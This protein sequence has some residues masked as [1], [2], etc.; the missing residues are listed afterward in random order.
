[1]KNSHP[2]NRSTSIDAVWTTPDETVETI[3]EQLR[4]LG[5]HRQ[6]NAPIL[7]RLSDGRIAPT[8]A[9]MLRKLAQE[10][11]A[12]ILKSRLAELIDALCPQPWA[13]ESQ[14]PDYREASAAAN[15]R[16]LPVI[17]TEGGRPA[18]L[19]L[20]PS[21]RVLQVAVDREAFDL[22]DEPC[23]P[24]ALA[25]TQFVTATLNT[26]VAKVAL[27]LKT[28][29]EPE[30]AYVVVEMDDGSF[31]VMTARD[32]NVDVKKAGADVWNL[33]LRLFTSRLRPAEVRECET[34]GQKQAQALA[35]KKKFLVLTA[36]GKPVGLVLSQD[37]PRSGEFE[38]EGPGYDLFGAPQSFLQSFQAE[39][40][41]KKA[42]RYVNLWFEDRRQRPINRTQALIIGDTYYLAMNV[43]QLQSDLSIINWE[44]KEP[45]GPQ[46]IV[47]P[48]EKEAHLYVSISSQDFAIPEPTRQLRLPKE[49]ST[50][51]IHIQLEPLHRSHG[52]DLA[53]LDVYLYYRTYLV[54]TFRVEVQVVA[55]NEAA[56]SARPQSAELTHARTTDFPQ[57]EKLPP[58]EMSLTITRNGADRY[59]FTFLIDPDLMDHASADKAIEL[60]CSVH[61]TRDDLTHLITKARRQLYN[62]AQI[63]DL[64]QVRDE[65][66][67]QR[68]T[69]ALARVGRQL[70]LKLFESSSARALRDW[71]EASLPEGST[72]Q[73]VDLAGDFVF[74]WSLVYTDQPW[75][76]D[77]PIDVAK[78]WGWRYKLV[79]LTSSLLDNYRQ[80]EPVISTDEPLRISIGLHERLIGADK[81]KAFFADLAS[82]TGH[83][84]MPEILTNRRV[85]SHALTDA[86][87]D[88][89]Y[90]FCHG[91]T[92]RIA[93]D[94]QLD[95]DLVAHFARTATENLASR[96]Q[97]IRDHLDDL[98]DVSDSWIRLT[99]GRLPLAM[100]KETV[101]DS[102]SRHPVVFLNMCE[103][104]QVL[105][106]LSDGFVPFFIQRGAR[107][108]IGTEC[109]MN[110]L[111][112]D[113]FAR[114]FLT[115]FFQ[116]EA[117]GDILLALR[118]HYL[119]QGNPLA[120]AY[121]LYCD[122]DL[123]LKEPVL[124]L[125]HSNPDT[126]EESLRTAVEMLWE[127]DLE[128]LMLTLAARIQV[129]EQGTTPEELQKWNPPE[130]TFHREA[131]ASPEAIAKMKAFAQKW[132]DNLEPKLYDLICNRDNEQ[133][134]Q[135]MN[136]L[137][138]G[139]K[140]LAMVLAPALVT[141]ISTLPA[142]AI[143]IATIAAKK[144]AESGLEAT[145]ELWQESREKAP[146]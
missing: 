138:D 71:I 17:A 55:A 96:S 45:G 123:R 5:G 101:P 94:I 91:Y 46:A 51:T 140:M 10:K 14:A 24:S 8:S 49:G 33:P 146:G 84:V 132:W 34:V 64:L 44:Q 135:L 27:D 85:M 77:K 23:D 100:L 79:I 114:A 39:I 113:D 66:A 90:F 41:P 1:M 129:Q 13:I 137:A 117:V 86:D 38:V 21:H 124:P 28:T 9:P 76:D 136:A 126:S 60:S 18:G 73:I 99:R 103:S 25:Q 144:I 53:T 111:F 127:D 31:R 42:P 63:F 92:E 52:S 82:R 139:A 11:G 118:R 47:E 16:Q 36:Q 78:F 104:A 48:Q 81:Q 19:A 20:P 131:E 119:A 88:L 15:Q 133:H 121:T 54:Q 116:G 125:D 105:P 106:S 40:Q 130:R 72:I 142:I 22:F 70:Y 29:R 61:L 65:Q 115:R 69:R 110:T 58:R 134:D 32:L 102:F 128:G 143:V 83:R 93:T 6:Y 43:G 75:D 97:S 35:N 122:A 80:A 3:R 98:F 56:S 67:Y 62:V 109:S 7:I 26:T 37:F 59:R 95:I 2:Q 107:A 108:V 141:Q 120:L 4:N 57:M 68:A 145:C 30:Q 87:R 12:T 50:E 74:P 89:Y 112:A